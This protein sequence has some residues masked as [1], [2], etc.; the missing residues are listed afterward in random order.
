VAAKYRVSDEERARRKE[1]MR[2][3]RASQPRELSVRGGITQGNRHAAEKT[4]VCG[5]TPEQ[6]FVDGQQ[7][8][9]IGGFKGSQN[10]ASKAALMAMTQDRR[11]QRYAAHCGMHRN[12][13]VVK[14]TCEFC[15]N[16]PSGEV[17]KEK[18]E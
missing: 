2:L 13:G 11:H 18:Y 17:P 4:G 10:P 1:N 12:R 7:G 15:M 16:P 14:I 9:L 3:L 5:R 6:Q 8:G